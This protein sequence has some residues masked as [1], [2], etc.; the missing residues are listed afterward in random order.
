MPKT[1]VRI[2]IDNGVAEESATPNLAPMLDT[3]FLV[4]CV[5]LVVF[6][7][8]TP[9]EG[10]PISFNS[11]MGSMESHARTQRVEVVMTANGDCEVNGRPHACAS[12]P[13]VL[14][15]MWENNPVEAIYL[16]AHRDA[17]YGKVAELLGQLQQQAERPVY[18]GTARK[19]ALQTAGTSSGAKRDGRRTE[20]NST[21]T[22]SN[23]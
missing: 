20:R 17:A 5:L 15:P 21:G 16:L 1:D 9:V 23:E 7:K 13:E 6:V 2:E 14:A 10:L 18:L 12:I 8:L 3:I 4:M 19:A 22:E 11:S